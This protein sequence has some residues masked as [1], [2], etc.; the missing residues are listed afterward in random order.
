MLP[1]SRRDRQQVSVSL[2]IGQGRITGREEINRLL[3]HISVIKEDASERLFM[4][5]EGGPDG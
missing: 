3:E 5:L 2:D 1:R 4:L